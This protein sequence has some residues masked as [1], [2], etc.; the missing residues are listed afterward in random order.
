MKFIGG[1]VS[2]NEKEAEIDVDVE[3][4]LVH[5]GTPSAR[6]DWTDSYG[7]E[8][9][10]DLIGISLYDSDELPIAVLEAAVKWPAL[11]LSEEVSD[12]EATQCG[13]R[14][15]ADII[16]TYGKSGVSRTII[17][18]ALS[19]T[20]SMSRKGLGTL[21]L[22]IAKRAYD[23]V[24]ATDDTNLSCND[25]TVVDAV[26]PFKGD[27]RLYRYMLDLWFNFDLELKQRMTSGVGAE[28]DPS[29]SDFFRKAGC[30]FD[31]ALG[32]FI[33]AQAVEEK[34]RVLGDK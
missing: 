25:L 16:S 9:G 13:R 29:L 7:L 30:L 1:R 8:E 5:I 14:T 19:V 31:K 28:A 6:T 20:P 33:V 10:S 11:K 12:L 34:W 24:N 32:R 17:V 21:L 23:K 3:D 27:P 2:T 15:L 26:V 4:R 18:T 22:A